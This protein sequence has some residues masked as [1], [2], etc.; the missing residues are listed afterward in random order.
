[1]LA[2]AA[3]R[4]PARRLKPSTLLLIAGGHALLLVGV[5]A[6]RN[7]VVPRT[8]PV[9]TTVVNVPLDPDPPEAKPLPKAEAKPAVSTITKPPTQMVLPMPDGPLTVTLSDPS[10]LSTRVGESHEPVAPLVVPLPE[11]IVERVPPPLVR[12]TPRLLTS[13]ERMRPP[14]PESKRRMEQEATLRLRLAIG[15]DGRVTSVEPVGAADPE[16]LAAARSHLIKVWRY[17]PARE[18]EAAVASSLVITLRFQL[19]GEE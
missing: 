17:A 7:E 16:F 6:I 13:G 9:P 12:S 1:M 2:Y 11:P 19:E 10:P 18:G 4:R 3:H 8:P 15:A 5:M 14:Y